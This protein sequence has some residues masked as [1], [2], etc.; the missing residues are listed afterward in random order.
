VRPSFRSGLFLALVAV[1]GGLFMW[2][3]T[4]NGV[5]VNTDATFYLKMAESIRTGQGVMVDGK[6]MA[7]FPPLYPLA[8]AVTGLFQ[9]DLLAAARLLQS[10]L[11]G[12]NAA[13]CAALV[14]LATRRNL[15]AAAA[16]ALLY[17]ASAPVIII[18]A[19]AQTEALFMTFL[20]SGL[21][22]L[23]LHIRQPHRGLLAAAS[24]SLGLA[25][26]T[27]YAGLGLMPALCACVLLL[28]GRPLGRRLHET[29]TAGFIAFTPVWLWWLRNLMLA[30][31]ATSR[32]LVFHPVSLAQ[33]QQLPG[34]VC[35]FL[36]PSVLP[37]PAEWLVPAL[38]AAFFIGTLTALKRKQ[39]LRREA[40]APEAVVPVLA[41]V[42]TASYL[43]FFLVS[44]CLFDA[45]SPLDTRMLLPAFLLLLPAGIALA[46]SLAQAMARPAIWGIFLAVALGLVGVTG[47][48]GE[49][50]AYYSHKNS[51]EF[52]SVHWRRS[53]AIAAVQKLD[54]AMKLYSNGPDVIEFITG[55]K[56]VMLPVRTDP[57]TR[58]PYPQY[59]AEWTAMTNATCSGTA[60]VAYL[61]DINWRWYLPTKGELE[62]QAHLPVL[63]QLSDGVIFGQTAA[64]PATNSPAAP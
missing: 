47:R 28:G 49:A 40:T 61:T 25:V 17:L 37:K 13:L 44:I 34:S 33:W 8:L 46:W 53:P 52:N 12:L 43:L 36:L 26:T 1:A 3:I 29:V 56:V 51:R 18:S 31:T 39:W 11:F 32:A 55:R 35:D 57:E 10:A 16:G 22:L 21:I 42:F 41:L 59:P 63:K 54:P 45:Y 27:R 50:E 48:R 14:L 15:A 4:A 60:V 24:L 38:V 19:I 58:R 64:P 5:G 30:E 62:T 23:A 7:H 6:P 20:F 2:W 9:G